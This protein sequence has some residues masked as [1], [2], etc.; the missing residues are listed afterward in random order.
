MKIPFSLALIC[1]AF[2]KMNAQKIDSVKFSMPPVQKEANKETPK[3]SVWDY[4]QVQV[5]PAF[6]GGDAGIIKYLGANLKYPNL[7]KEQGIQ[8]KVYI[9]F[10]I[11]K[12]GSVS[13]VSVK[14]GIGG[15]CDEEALRVIKK[16]PKWKPGKE[17]GKPVRVRRVYPLTFKMQ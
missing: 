3:D 6:P 9:I 8:G 13:D 5:K 14:S 11:N 17:N 1:L 10:I 15:G 12:N 16:M 4:L 2:F 7:A